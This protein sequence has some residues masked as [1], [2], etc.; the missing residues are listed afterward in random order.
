MSFTLRR[1]REGRM[2]FELISRSNLCIEV[3]DGRL[4]TLT[5]VSAIETHALKSQIPLIIVLNKCDLVPRDVCE[6]N[7]RVFSHEFPTV[8]ISAQERKGTKKL[9]EQ[10]ARLSSHKE[11]HISIVGIPNTGKSSLLNV[12][13]GKHV[14]PTGQKPGV[15][16]S[17]QLVRISRRMMIFDTPG[18]V[19]FD[20]QDENIQ[21]FLGALPLEKL[22]DPISTVDFFLDRI[23]LHHTEGMQA[24][25]ELTSL[26]M[27]TEAILSH[28]ARKRGLVLKG[29][30]LNVTGA[31][32][33]LMSELTAGIFPYWE[34]LPNRK[35]AE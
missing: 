35:S 7:K 10:I 3:V 25:Y 29:G 19:P 1:K 31:A 21:A 11:I 32:K 8:Y 33:V 12:L 4:P 2:V 18:V 13:R 27:D 5:R 28:I 30:E 17:K 9:R 22:E 26:D 15:T 16:R 6:H 23:R 24:R 34:E 20:H 14:A